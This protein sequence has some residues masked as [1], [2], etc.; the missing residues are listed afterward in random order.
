MRISAIMTMYVCVVFALVSFWFSWSSLSALE[1]LTDQAER[2][3]AS[4]YGWFWLFLGGVATVFGLVS[5]AMAKG[6]F[7]FGDEIDQ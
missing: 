5:W 1:R 7:G 2:D 6:K 3:M 4:G